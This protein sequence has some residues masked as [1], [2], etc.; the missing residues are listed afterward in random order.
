MA[1]LACLAKTSNVAFGASQRPLAT[2]A[3]K[4]APIDLPAVPYS[5]H[6]MWQR[7]GSTSL[8]VK[9]D[10]VAKAERPVCE[11]ENAVKDS[12]E[13]WRSRSFLGRTSGV[14]SLE[15]LAAELGEATQGSGARQ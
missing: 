15:T 7:E 11:I 13:A 3:V 8:P 9:A 2:R 4:R 12:L 14:V 6:A 1:R 10:A 5:A